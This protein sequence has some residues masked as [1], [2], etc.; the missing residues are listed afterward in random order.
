M[1]NILSM[2]NI[3]G[4]TGGTLSPVIID[5]IIAAIILLAA[6]I[7][8]RIGLYRSVMSVVVFVLA[9]VIGIA[10]S[11]IALQ[12]VSEYAW[13]KAA[14][15]I[16]AK[17]DKEAADLI[18]GENSS[19]KSFSE[20]W[21]KLVESFGAEG[22]K[23]IGSQ[24]GDD[25]LQNSEFVAKLKLVVLANT[26]LF[27]DKI[28]RIV[29]FVLIALLAFLILTVIKNIL[30][31]LTKLPVIG[32]LDHCGGFALGLIEIVLLMLVIVRGAGL[33]HIPVFTELSKG[34]FIL[35]W[36]VGGDLNDAL[37]SIKSLSLEDLK[38]IDLEEL[39]KI[40][41]KNIGS[42]L[43]DIAHLLKLPGAD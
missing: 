25:V 30:G 17:F 38:N 37:S 41:L 22:L 18:G 13:T 12:P 2:G 4:N 27:T 14:P 43:K 21:D 24:L 40:D 33:L 28:M 1:E 29:L 5:V 6:F 9:I 7:K 42:Q 20:G 39:K 8:S 3:P 31:K 19:G 34:T 10:G 36:L 11:A 32:W 23:G 16:E 26:R 35:K 15:R